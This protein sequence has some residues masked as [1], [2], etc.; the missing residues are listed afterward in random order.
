MCLH[1]V[2]D[3]TYGLPVKLFEYMAAGLPIIASNFPL[4]G[5]F[6][7]EHGCGITVNPLNAK[8][9]ARAIEHL[10]DHPEERQ[11]MGENGRRAVLE[12]YNWKKESEK[13]LKLYE[14][15]LRK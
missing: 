7:K 15:L 6:F 9:I 14:G 4:W 13:L 8:E 1:P 3:Y 11:K 10:L 2:G 12:K 5:N